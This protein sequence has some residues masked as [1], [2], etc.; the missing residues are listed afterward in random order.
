MIATFTSIVACITGCL[1]VYCFMVLQ[2]KRTAGK[3]NIL[4]IGLGL[5]ALILWILT[6]GLERAIAI[7]L[8]QI[9]ATGVVLSCGFAL[10]D[11]RK[12]QE[13]TTDNTP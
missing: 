11:A 4:F 3:S 7:W 5:L 10:K 9:M 12:K 8:V 1:C 2:H 13:K 6:L